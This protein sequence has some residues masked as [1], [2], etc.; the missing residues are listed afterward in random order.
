M[1]PL[2]PFPKSTIPTTFQVHQ[3]I[4][5]AV[6]AS[7]QFSLTS[8]IGISIFET[9]AANCTVLHWFSI[10]VYERTMWQ[11]NW[12]ETQEMIFTTIFETNNHESRLVGTPGS[13]PHGSMLGRCF[14][15]QCPTSWEVRFWFVSAGLLDGDVVWICFWYSKWLVTRI[16]CERKQLADHQI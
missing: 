11:K 2:Q 3:W 1:W 10:L 4:R 12:E 5:P 14:T 8:P 13:E 16:L 6:D 9:S 15:L 7:Q